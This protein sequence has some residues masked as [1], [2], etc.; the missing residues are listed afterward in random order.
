MKLQQSVRL[1]ALALTVIFSGPLFAEPQYKEMVTI[2]A[3]EFEMGCKPSDGVYCVPGTT[4]HKVYLKTYKIDKYMVTFDRFQACIDAGKCTKPFEGAAC[5][6]G[7]EFAGN[8][9]ANC[10]TYKQ[11]EDVCHFE[12]KRLP[13]EA[14]W[15]KAARGPKSTL[16]PWGNTPAPSCERVVMNDKGFDK[17]PGCGSG[18]TQPVG[19]KPEGAS[20]YGVMDMAG[21]LFQWTSD[22]YSESYFGNSPYKNPKGPDYGEKKVLR[23]SG[24]TARY[25][26][27]IAMTVRFDY[28]PDGQGYVVGARCANDTN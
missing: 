9:P 18:T 20:T 15:A 25:P 27:E 2:P 5:N 17:L 22:W 14:E 21:N 13:T 10:I 24:W 4:P 11:A 6:Y 19:S 7:E 1:A 3:G 26:D 16:Y 28:A 12:G 8:H 23:G